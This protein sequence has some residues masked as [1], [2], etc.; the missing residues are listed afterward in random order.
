MTKAQEWVTYSA[1]SERNS[2]P[3][4]KSETFFFNN[5]IKTAAHSFLHVTYYLNRLINEAV[6]KPTSVQAIAL[7]FSY[8]FFISASRL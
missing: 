7:S 5:P 8:F 6:V 2:N 1:Q 3:T 4:H